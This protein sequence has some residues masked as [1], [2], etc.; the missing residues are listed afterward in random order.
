MARPCQARRVPG[1]AGGDIYV[2]NDFCQL[3]G[4]AFSLWIYQETNQI[5]GLQRGDEVEN[6]VSNCTGIAADTDIF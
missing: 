2:D 3:D 5:D 1:A 6:D 4:C